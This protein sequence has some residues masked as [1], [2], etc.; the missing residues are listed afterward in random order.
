MDVPEVNL[1]RS[2]R[3]R[4]PNSRLLNFITGSRA[5][6][7][8]SRK[9]DMPMSFDDI[10]GR[11]DTKEWIAA[12][13]AELHSMSKNN[14]WQIVQIPPS[15]KLLKSRW[16]F[17]I[18]VDA[19]G[20]PTRYKA[21][22]VVKGFLQKYGIDYTETYAP[23][24]KLTTIRVVLAVGVYHNYKFHQLDIKT[25]FLHGRLK[26]DIY[27]AVPDGVKIDDGNACKLLRS[28]YG[29]KQSPRCWNEEFNSYLESLSFK[30][31]RHDYCL[32]TKI[33]GKQFIVLILYV[34][35]I[36]MTG[37]DEKAIENLKKELSSRFDMSD[38]GELKYF[39]GMK[40]ERNEKSLQISQAAS[41][42]KFLEKFGLKDCNTVKTPMEKGLQLEIEKE[43]K[44][45]KPYRELL[46]SM[47][48][49]MLCCRPDICYNVSYMGRFQQES[50]D[51]HFQHLKRIARYLK[52]TK[53]MKLE[54]KGHSKIPL[55][56]YVDS[57]W[58]SDTNDRKSTS[59][60]IFQVY[61]STVAWSSKKQTTVATS[62]SE[63]E[64]VSLSAGV[65]EAI[66]LRGIMEDLHQIENEAT[67]IYEDNHGC[68]GMAKNCESKRAKHIDI[69]HHFIRD[70]VAN[71]NI[72]IEAIKSEEQLADLFT[73][74]LDTSRYIT[75]RNMI[76]IIN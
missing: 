13:D 14:V 39:L 65:Q 6:N 64:Y 18:K 10:F 56:G 1:R 20:N 72:Q 50:T 16:V 17:T 35:D 8:N 40:I 51:T 66:W 68:I 59:G 46:G 61:G 30:R 44:T 52:A 22:L 29:L 19:D 73:K 37:S 27:M 43:T 34:D 15:S 75:L 48:Y 42:E 67:T 49:I 31:S 9:N 33:D 55:V 28:L 60:F 69:K 2:E 54:F 47:M 76:G 23:V 12:V 21:R 58:A 53:D 45:D 63:A 5:Y 41:I 11:P 24:A 38:C 32:Y 36:L 4:K 25:A 62:S 70:H 57:D 7:T 74:S 71:G 26:E 3:E